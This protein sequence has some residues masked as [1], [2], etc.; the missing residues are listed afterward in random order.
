MGRICGKSCDL[1][2]TGQISLADNKMGT[3]FTIVQDQI[4][5]NKTIEVNAA[6]AYRI[7]L[8][9]DLEASFGLQTGM[10]NY[11][12]DYSG[13][14][15]DRT[16]PKFNNVSEMKRNFGAGL[17]VRSETFM[18]SLAVPHMLNSSIDA[19][20]VTTGLYQRN[21]Y[22]FGAYLFPVSYRV[23]RKPSILLRASG[24]LPVA[25]DYCIAMRMDD[26]Y[27]I[28]LLTR[29]FQTVGFQ[30]S[31]NVGDALRFAYVFEMPLNSATE[32]NFSSHEFMV[33]I[34]LKALRFHDLI[35]IKNF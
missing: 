9:N 22:A 20:G 24:G 30:A 8:N 12:S 26:S 4:G 11:R 5:S 6:Y 35:E 25:V 28:G 10:V 13:L 29:N 27:T 34:R 14:Q 33:G 21:L 7:K 3:G 18:I 31:I 23:K 15:I 17:L 16:D 32:L 19:N 2:L 1:N